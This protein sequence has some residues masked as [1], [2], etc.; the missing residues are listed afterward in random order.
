MAE[1]GGANRDA[2]VGHPS[3]VRAQVIGVGGDQDPALG[4]G[5]REERRVGDAK[6]SC[7]GCGRGVD[8]TPAKTVGHGARYVLVGE[9][10]NPTDHLS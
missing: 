10:S 1:P 4:P 3:G 7:F 2:R 9:V 5:E 8:A 6:L